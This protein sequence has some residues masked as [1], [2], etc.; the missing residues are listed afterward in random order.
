MNPSSYKLE[1]PFLII[2]SFSHIQKYKKKAY[3]LSK[4]LITTNS[5][6][7]LGEMEN[8]IA[9]LIK[10]SLTSFNFHSWKPMKALLKMETL[11][12]D[13]SLKMSFLVD[14]YK[15]TKFRCWVFCE[16]WQKKARKMKRT[17]MRERGT[18]KVEWGCNILK[19]H[20]FII[21][22]IWVNTSWV[23]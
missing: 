23:F 5:T 14:F 18:T 6:I 10:L 1:I 4:F 12:V 19:I 8:D 2:Y 3:K 21:V 9:N 7:K 17:S 22:L 15:N 11:K 16:I 20:I 13:S